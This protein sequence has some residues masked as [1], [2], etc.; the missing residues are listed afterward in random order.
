MFSC[1]AAHLVPIALSSNERSCEPA[2][3]QSMDVDEDSVKNSDSMQHRLK[4]FSVNA[5]CLS[6][7]GPTMPQLEVCSALAGCELRAFFF[8]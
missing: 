6:K 5:W 3:T 2:Q 8:V 7:A 4:T 1:V